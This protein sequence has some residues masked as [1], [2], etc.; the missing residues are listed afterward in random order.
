MNL[1]DMLAA[2]ETESS[3]TSC[4]RMSNMTAFPAETPIGMAYVPYQQWRKVYEPAV[5][6]E[7]GTIFEELD[8]P[9]LGE[10]AV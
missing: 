7:R 2:A 4:S 10:K 1:T 6:L 9:F 3:C 8:K 5:A